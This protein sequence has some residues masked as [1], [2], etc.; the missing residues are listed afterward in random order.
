MNKGKKY[1]SSIL[2]ETED[3]PYET[4]SAYF[5]IYRRG[6]DSIDVA[7]KKFNEIT[8]EDI[9]KIASKIH[10]DT[11]YTLGGDKKWWS[12]LLVALV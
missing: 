7:I 5:Q 1:Y 12:I 10:M 8:K 2:E 3:Y 6:S 4:A 11:V 9:I